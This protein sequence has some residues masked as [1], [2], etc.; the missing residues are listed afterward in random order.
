[1]ST[2]LQRAGHVKHVANGCVSSVA[3]NSAA[4]VIEGPMLSTTMLCDASPEI[5]KQILGERLLPLVR[6]HKVSSTFV[7][8]GAKFINNFLE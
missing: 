2:R 4:A 7:L 3:S 1:M 5:Q 8:D 6:Q